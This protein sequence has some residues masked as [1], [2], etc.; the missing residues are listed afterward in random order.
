LLSAGVNGIADA[1]RL[2]AARPQARSD[3]AILRPG[4]GA[5][6]TPAA[7]AQAAAPRAAPGGEIAFMTATAEAQPTPAP[8]RSQK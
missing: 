1:K 3:P 4:A 2:E 8:S 5:K 6:T 7:A